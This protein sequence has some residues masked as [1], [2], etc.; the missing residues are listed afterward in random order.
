MIECLSMIENNQQSLLNVLVGNNTHS[1]LNNQPGDNS[2]DN[3]KQYIQFLEPFLKAAN[4]RELRDF[5]RCAVELLNET[6]QRL[7][8]SSQSHSSQMYFKDPQL[9]YETQ[10]GMRVGI[11]S[12]NA[13]DNWT[14]SKLDGGFTVNMCINLMMNINSNHSRDMIAP[15][16]AKCHIIPNDV[17][18]V[19][20]TTHTMRDN[21]VNTDKCEFNEDNI[22]ELL[23][24]NDNRD[25]F[26]MLKYALIFV[27]IIH[28][29]TTKTIHSNVNSHHSILDQIKRFT[30]GNGLFL[31]V[32]NVGPSRSGFASSSAV[33]CNILKVLYSCCSGL[34]YI[35]NDGILLGSM[36]LLLEN[37]LG[38]KS[39]RQD[40]DGLLENGLKI[41]HYS[42]TTKFLIPEIDIRRLDSRYSKFKLQYFSNNLVLVNS[43]IARP[44]TLGLH[45]GLN[46]R[47]WAYLSRDPVRYKAIKESYFIHEQIICA[48]EENNMYVAHVRLYFLYYS[49]HLQ[50]LFRQTILGVYGMQREN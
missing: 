7:L 3:F 26:R 10:S 23:H 34:E 16:M 44:H 45:R 30:K 49:L 5:N 9:I 1:L 41:L 38:L 47:F 33:A 14:N 15:V 37:H 43:G 27:G 4:E 31:S 40:V 20:E 28:H 42:Q 29:P 35:A 2:D 6:K 19:L 25:I 13:S 22:H 50:L 48:I 11:S 17:K 36:A 32:S 8:L 24:F 12:A 21:M 39:G 46:M 18:I